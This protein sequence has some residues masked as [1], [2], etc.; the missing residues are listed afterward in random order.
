MG[1]E[2]KIPRVSMEYGGEPRLSAKS[3]VIPGKGFQRIP[4]RVKHQRVDGFLISPGEIPELFGYGKS[5]KKI[6][7]W[8]A[9][10]QLL[11]D[12]LLT[13]M[14]LAMRAVPVAAGMR[15]IDF[16]STLMIRALC[17]HMLAMFLP[18]PG[19]DP[20]SLFVAGQHG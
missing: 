13:F 20:Q 14:V 12:P 7:G 8:Q 5:D 11:F 17:Q 9:L 19:D 1:M 10:V 2:I 4:D 15:N 3:F 6:G 18:A 16:L